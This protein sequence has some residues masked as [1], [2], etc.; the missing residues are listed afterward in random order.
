MPSRAKREE[1]EDSFADGLTVLL[2]DYLVNETKHHEQ[3]SKPCQRRQSVQVKQRKVNVAQTLQS[4][5][6]EGIP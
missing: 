2:Q 1:V 6:E 3:R 5:I 4:S